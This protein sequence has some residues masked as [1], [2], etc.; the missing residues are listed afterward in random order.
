MPSLRLIA[1]FPAIRDGD[2]L[3]SNLMDSQ[4]LNGAAKRPVSGTGNG[5]PKTA[6]FV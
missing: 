1:R 2:P 3:A 5:Y 4:Q 6:G